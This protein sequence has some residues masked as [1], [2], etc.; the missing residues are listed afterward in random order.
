VQDKAIEYIKSGNIEA[1]EKMTEE[2]NEEIKFLDRLHTKSGKSSLG[3]AA[4]EGRIASMTVLLKAKAS[5]DLV[6]KLGMTAFLYAG[7]SGEVDILEMLHDADTDVH[8][9]TTAKN[10]NALMLATKG[11][12]L[13]CVELLNSYHLAVDDK[14]TQEETA[15]SIA[16]KFEYYPL[17]S[18]LVEREADINV[19]GVNGNTPLIRTAFDGRLTTAQFILN[20]KGNV[21]MT[22]LNGES[23]LMIACRHGHMNV[24]ALFIKSG[25]DINL[26]DNS[27]RTALMICSMVGKHDMLQFLVENGADVNLADSWGY[28]ALMYACVRSTAGMSEESMSN[29]L[30]SIELLLQAGAHIDA[31]DK[32]FN[33]SLMHCCRKG[34]MRVASLLLEAGADPR[35]RSIDDVAMED[36]ISSEEDRELFID[37]IKD[38][39]ESE[40]SQLQGRTAGTRP[41][42]GW[43]TELNNLRKK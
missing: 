20:N 15:L 36:L 24:A 34:N 40:S 35:I 9:K 5:V 10:E 4:E 33:T 38:I 43:I 29:H 42:P 25:A 23:A 26:A 12:H 7:M 8:V 17:C 16:L 11:N 30:A 6:D 41:L 18:Y 3:V 32:N 39:H 21:N 37:A 1:L 22:N 19:L 14:N 27:G 31:M 28:S 13:K 2:G